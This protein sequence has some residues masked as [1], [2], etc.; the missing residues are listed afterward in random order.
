MSEAVVRII[1]FLHNLQLRSTETFYKFSMTKV[2]SF[3]ETYKDTSFRLKSTSFRPKSS[4]QMENRYAFKLYPEN[5]TRLNRTGSTNFF[6]N[7]YEWCFKDKYTWRTCYLFVELF[8]IKYF[9]NIF[10]PIRYHSGNISYKMVDKNI[11]S[12]FFDIF[13]SEYYF[14]GPRESPHQKFHQNS[15][16]QKIR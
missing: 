1:L 9:T 13:W 15:D 16:R 7:A 8:S 6:Y 4:K 10:F 2:H 12:N 14:K 5:A 3:Q 11:F